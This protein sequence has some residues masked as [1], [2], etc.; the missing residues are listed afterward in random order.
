VL[1]YTLPSQNVIAYCNIFFTALPAL[2]GTCHA[3]D[4]ATTILHE[5][6]HAP[7]VYSPG[8]QDNGYG[9]TAATSLSSSQAVAN[10]D[11]YALYANGNCPHRRP[12]RISHADVFV[13]HLRGL[14]DIPRTTTILTGRHFWISMP[15]RVVVV[16][17]YRRVNFDAFESFSAARYTRLPR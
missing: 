10:A 11:S 12:C 16:V 7:A 3:Q 13:S 1:A 8:T 14:L 9:Y 6:T 17:D 15:L 5:E 4:Q 2:S